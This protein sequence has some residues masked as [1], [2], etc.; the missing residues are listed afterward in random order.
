M[1]RQGIAIVT[2]ASRGIGRAT[3]LRLGADGFRLLL[4]AR[5]SADLLS[6]QDELA[7]SS[8]S[9]EVHPT[10]LAKPEDVNRLCQQLAAGGPYDV[11]V[12]NA[13]CCE[14][15]AFE[16]MSDAS[17]RRHF[18]VNVFALQAL[19]RAVIPAMTRAG[20][21]S[22]VNIASISGIRGTSKFSGFAAYA[23]AKAAVIVLS[24]ALAAEYASAGLRINSISP[25]AVDT[26]LLA[27]VAPGFPPAMSP[28]EIA[29]VVSML[30]SDA[31]RAFNGR[32]I[33][34]F[35]P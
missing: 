22:I 31:G 30:C 23:A 24:E 9:V 12:N 14:P 20:R 10:D 26:A 35:G 5:P 33:E 3:A 27:K 32:N 6:L 18:E 1:S 7:Q 8:I 34:V 2:G 28:E 25:G 4:V 16:A 21:G 15:E 13:G 29:S 11:L 19:S 17:F